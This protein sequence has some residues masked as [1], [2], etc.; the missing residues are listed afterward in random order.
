METGKREWSFCLKSPLAI[1][2]SQVFSRRF[3]SDLQEAKKERN[4]PPHIPKAWLQAIH[5]ILGGIALPSGNPIPCI[6]MTTILS[7]E[8]DWKRVF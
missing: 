2:I 3:P 8:W 7:G 5:P 4:F 6:S 1:Y